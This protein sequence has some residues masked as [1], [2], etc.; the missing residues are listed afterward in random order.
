MVKAVPHL[1][2]VLCDNERA[3]LATIGFLRFL[4]ASNRA[5]SKP[6][7]YVSLDIFSRVAEARRWFGAC[8]YNKRHDFALKWPYRIRA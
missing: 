5:S 3:P 6:C 4:D 7:V 1:S 8:I 2:F